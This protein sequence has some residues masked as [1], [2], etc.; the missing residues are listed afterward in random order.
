M[1]EAIL[2]PLDRILP[3]QLLSQFSEWI[4]FGLILVF[5]ISVAGITLRRHFDRPYVKPLIISVGLMLTVGVFMFKN[6]LVMIFEGWGILGLV[7]LVFLVATIPFGLCRGY[8]MPAK[9]AI[10]MTYILFFILAWFKFPVFYYSLANHNLGL[11]NL[12]LLILFFVAVFKM[13][14]L[15]KS[16]NNYVK[17]LVRTSPFRPEIQQELETQNKEENLVKNNA[18][19]ITKVEIRTIKDM[20]EALAEI[21][22][23]VETNNNIIPEKEREKITEILQ[24]LSNKENI[25]KEGLLSLQKKFKQIGTIDTEQLQNLKE[26]LKK[27]SEKEQKILKSEI[28]FEEEKLRTEKMILDLEVR[29]NQY[30]ESFNKFLAQSIEYLGGPEKLYEVKNYFARARLLLND[31]SE[32]LKETKSLEEKLINLTKAEKTLLKKEKETS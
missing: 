23:I 30:I 13:I 7:L 14:P 28:K 3:S 24:M 5:F 27:A 2:Y 6:Q 19:K 20:A 29:L 15:G 4:Y 21:Q 26:R 8:G 22:R 10:A 1:A 9:K 18:L 16:R 17:D 11:V 32:M 25:L 12:G 31:I